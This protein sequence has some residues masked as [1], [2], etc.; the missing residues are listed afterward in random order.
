MKV[1]KTERNSIKIIIE[2]ITFDKISD[3]KIILIKNPREGGS[4]ARLIRQ[5]NKKREEEAIKKV[6]FKIEEIFFDLSLKIKNMEIIAYKKNI[7]KANHGDRIN[8][9]RTQEM[10]K[11]EDSKTILR[12]EEKEKANITA[13]TLEERLIVKIEVNDIVV[14]KN[15]GAIFCQV[16]SII[17]GAQETRD[18]I[19]KYQEWVGNIPNLIIMPIRI[20]G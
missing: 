12:R 7:I 18:P 14:E 17:R 11:I 10:F 15:N 9:G 5:K 4:P 2:N 19:F 16:R 8:V 20:I 13:N 1:I 6:F 3:M